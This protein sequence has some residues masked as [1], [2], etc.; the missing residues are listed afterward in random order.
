MT[1]AQKLTGITA[2]AT[3]GAF[4]LAG[5]LVKQFTGALRAAFGAMLAN[6][7]TAIIAGLACIGRSYLPSSSSSQC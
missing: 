4:K 7:I 1:I 2:I 3:G 5:F 6:P